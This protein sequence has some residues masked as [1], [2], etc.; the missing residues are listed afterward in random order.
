LAENGY[1]KHGIREYVAKMKY[2]YLGKTGLLVSGDLDLEEEIWRKVK[3]VSEPEPDAL[4][5]QD[6]MARKTTYGEE[7]F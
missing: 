4:V 7:E 6:L 1:S 3:E 5:K 2:R